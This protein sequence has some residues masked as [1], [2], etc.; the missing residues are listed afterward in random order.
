MSD[1][2]RKSSAFRTALVGECEAEFLPRLAILLQIARV[3]GHA[4]E[5]STCQRCFLPVSGAFELVA[6]RVGEIIRGWYTLGVDADEVIPPQSPEVALLLEI[7]HSAADVGDES[8][9]A[10]NWRISLG[11][12]GLSIAKQWQGTVEHLEVAAM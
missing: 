4:L 8:D 6:R 2:I 7:C 12:S 3:Y 5:C 11:L 9:S 10:N 1:P